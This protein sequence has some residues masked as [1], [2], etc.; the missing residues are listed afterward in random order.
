MRNKN[1]GPLKRYCACEIQLKTVVKTNPIL[2]DLALLD[3][4]YV[5]FYTVCVLTF[6]PSSPGGPCEENQLKQK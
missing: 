5:I 2:S 6:I 1:F 3:H 4:L